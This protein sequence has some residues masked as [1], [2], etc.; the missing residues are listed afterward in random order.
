M[1]A[2]APTT[3]TVVVSL[4]VRSTDICTHV[5]TLNLVSRAVTSCRT[6]VELKGEACVLRAK[7]GGVRVEAEGGGVRVEAEGGGVRRC[8]LR[9][10][11]WS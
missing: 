11:C 2:S 1:R 9:R 4:A 8:E 3:D 7:G 10:V 6:M 5:I